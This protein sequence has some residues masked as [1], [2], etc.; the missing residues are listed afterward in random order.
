M[1]SINTIIFDFDGVICDSVNIKTEAFIE[2]YSNYP[3]PITESVKKYHLEHG[4]ISRFEKIKYF[5][6][7]L[8]KNEYNSEIISKKAQIFSNLVKN[9]VVKS[10]YITGV[11]NFIKKN[12]NT[13][14]FICTGTPESEI[15]D[16]VHKREINS[17]FTGVFGSPKSKEKI[18]HNI[19]LKW[20]I[21]PKEILYFGDA[22]TDLY[23]SQKYGI[24]F[25]G[26]KN[27]DTKFPDNIN[28]INDFYDDFLNNIEFI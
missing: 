20:K 15:I 19:I 9:K 4:G 17:Y 26:I 7:V 1:N 23:A 13:L 6:T 10:E 22:M 27:L 8:L 21:D 24:N 18:I 28:I 16:I 12:H 5:E 25:V 3:K 11:I 2:L 14:K